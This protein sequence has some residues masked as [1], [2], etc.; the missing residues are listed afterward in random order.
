MHYFAREWRTEGV[1][2]LNDIGDKLNFNS[3]KAAKRGVAMVTV[4]RILMAVPSCGEI[5]KCRVACI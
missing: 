5:L 3:K 4:S 2:L 1:P